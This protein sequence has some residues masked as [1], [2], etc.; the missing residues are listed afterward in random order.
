MVE[1]IEEL[2][3]ESQILP[4]AQP[5]R[6]ADRKVDIHLVRAINAIARRVSKTGSP[7]GPMTGSGT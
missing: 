4:F 5:K 6:L 1:Q 7:S 3:A 2:R